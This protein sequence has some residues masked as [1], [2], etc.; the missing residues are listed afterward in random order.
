MT[1]E[2]QSLIDWMEK[3]GGRKMTEKEINWALFRAKRI[4]SID[5]PNVPQV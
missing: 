2:E 3:Q 1:E 4:G 5:N